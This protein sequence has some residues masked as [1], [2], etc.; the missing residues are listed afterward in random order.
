M[1]V[2]YL[3]RFVAV[4]IIFALLFGLAGFLLILGAHT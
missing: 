1:T 3:L 4:L 2:T